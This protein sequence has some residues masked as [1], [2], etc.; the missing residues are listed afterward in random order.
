[1]LRDY[2]RVSVEHPNPTL[3]FMDIRIYA[4]VLISEVNFPALTYLN[5]TL[6]P[7]L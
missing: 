7:E 6:I 2:V 5:P 4:A 1:M 3:Y